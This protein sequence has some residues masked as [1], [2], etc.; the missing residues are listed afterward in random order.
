MTYPSFGAASVAHENWPVH[1]IAHTVE[2]LF[3]FPLELSHVL[4]RLPSWC[5]TSSHFLEFSR[6]FT[7]IIKVY[8]CCRDVENWESKKCMFSLQ[9]VPVR[10]HVPTV[11]VFV[12]IFGNTSEYQGK[13]HSQLL[14]IKLDFIRLRHWNAWSWHGRDLQWGLATS[15]LDPSLTFHSRVTNKVVMDNCLSL[16]RETNTRCQL[17]AGQSGKT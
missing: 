1:T 14:L 9:L 15:I 17:I 8:L 5:S 6:A 3:H 16:K 10:L 11:F 4:Q 2:H 7:K 12:F 13:K